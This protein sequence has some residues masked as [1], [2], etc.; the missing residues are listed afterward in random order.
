M[1]RAL[2]PSGGAW[3]RWSRGVR[4]SASCPCRVRLRR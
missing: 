1:R 4:A 2:D 3:P